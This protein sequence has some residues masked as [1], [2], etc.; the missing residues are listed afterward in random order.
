MKENGWKLLADY[1]TLGCLA[2]FIVPPLLYCW[3]G[4]VFQKLWE[5]FIV[6]RFSQ[7]PLSLPSAIGIGV[8]VG[9]ITKQ[10]DFTK[11]NREQPWWVAF[12]ISMLW[13]LV[14]LFVGYIAHLFL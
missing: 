4:F 10:P 8:L 3:N 7:T 9:Y 12:L 5:W 6:E 11:E 13:P 1:T 2:V 14:A